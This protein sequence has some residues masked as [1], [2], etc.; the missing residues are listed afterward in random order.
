MNT[1]GTDHNLDRLRIK[2]LLK[3]G[4][5]ASI[6]TGIGDYLLGYARIP[7]LSVPQTGTPIPGI[8]NTCPTRTAAAMRLVLQPAASAH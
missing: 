4:L 6:L 7:P 1:I 8:W 2:K 3:I 5:F